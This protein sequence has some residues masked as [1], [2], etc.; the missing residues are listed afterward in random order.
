VRRERTAKKFCPTSQQKR[1]ALQH[2]FY[3]IDQLLN[4]LGLLVKGIVKTN[5]PALSN[6]LG[7]ALLES[8]LLHARILLD[9]FERS[10]RSTG[11]RNREQVELDDVLVID[12][13][14][15]PC[16]VEI[17]PYYRR[18]LNKD[19]AH[20]TYSRGKRELEE[21][22]WPAN[23]I[24]PPILIRSSEFIR[25]LLSDYYQENSAEIQPTKQEWES[26]L[27][28]IENC[29]AELRMR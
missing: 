8:W 27:K 1:D 6:I 15:E 29:L 26:L 25:H 11:R 14:F 16:E 22:R 2:V 9:F 18:R 17:D 28:A 20:L 3:E 5:E 24:V 13:G 7:N 21:K 4:A 12:Y 19:L 10:K 23:Q